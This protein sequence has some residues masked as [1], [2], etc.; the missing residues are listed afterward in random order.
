MVIL[1]FF[2]ANL[3]YFDSDSGFKFEIINIWVID[4]LLDWLEIKD[5]N[6]RRKKPIVAV[7]MYLNKTMPV[8]SIILNE[9]VKFSTIITARKSSCEKVMFSQA[10][11]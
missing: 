1:K 2:R 9:D 4:L 3:N 5:F 10:S 11:S 6:W 7:A 8:Y